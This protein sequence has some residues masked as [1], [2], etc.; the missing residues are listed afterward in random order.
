[1]LGR[2]CDK[3]VKVVSK[4]KKDRVAAK[5]T[6]NHSNLECTGNIKFISRAEELLCT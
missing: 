6:G 2:C 1:M 4:F 3:R 5:F